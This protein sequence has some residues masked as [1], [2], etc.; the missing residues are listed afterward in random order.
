MILSEKFGKNVL[1]I[2]L[3]QKAKFAFKWKMYQ[4]FSI[5]K[6][7]SF[8]LFLKKKPHKTSFY[9]CIVSSVCEGACLYCHTPRKA[10]KKILF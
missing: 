6:P 2:P 7:G 8:I 1:V 3:K 5:C 4:S 9:I 10:F